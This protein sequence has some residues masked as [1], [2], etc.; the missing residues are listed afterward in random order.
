M[1]LGFCCVKRKQPV[2]FERN[3]ESNHH[4]F[5]SEIEIFDFGAI[6][7]PPRLLAVAG[8][9]VHCASAP[10]ES[11]DVRPGRI[12]PF[13]GQWRCESNGEFVAAIEKTGDLQL[14]ACCMSECG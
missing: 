12:F 10:V 7:I 1:S 5:R 8:N 13:A 2:A 14:F 4:R 6:S 11:I 9:S 3:R